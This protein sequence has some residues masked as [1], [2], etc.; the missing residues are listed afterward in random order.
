[1]IMPSR[2]TKG[3][4]QTHNNAIKL[5]MSLSIVFYDAPYQLWL[6]CKQYFTVLSNDIL[7]MS[8]NIYIAQQTL[9]NE[10]LIPGILPSRS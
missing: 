7:Y 3:D 5:R 10:G 6:K 2:A 1:M 8:A 4:P 9:S